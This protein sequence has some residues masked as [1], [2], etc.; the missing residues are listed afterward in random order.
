[1]VDVAAGQAA[2]PADEFDP[3]GTP[4]IRAGSVEGLMARAN[5]SELEHLSDV[6]ARKRRMKLFPAE[7]VL[8]AKSGMSAALGRVFRIDRPAYVVSHLAA[9]KPT[10]KADPSFL[11][12]WL[13]YY[14]TQRLI[15]DP[16]YPSIRLA[17][18]EEMPFPN[19]PLPEQ[20]RISAILD[21]ADALR[22]LADDAIESFDE[23][24]IA[25]YYLRFGD[26]VSNNMGWPTIELSDAL[27][28]IEG[29]WSPTCLDRPACKGEWGVLKLGAVTYGRYN[30]SAN[31]ALPPTLVARQGLEVQK[32]DIL[33]SRKNTYDLVGASVLVAEVAERLI[34]PDLI[35][36]LKL[37]SDNKFYTPEFL[38]T[39]LATKSMRTVIKSLASGAAGS[40]PNISK[41]RLNSLQIPCPPIDAQLHYAKFRQMHE[42]QRSEM[43]A[44][45][46]RVVSLFTSLQHRAF[47]GE[48]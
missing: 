10:G 43:K 20:R 3:A 17:D 41:G 34:I 15:K 29:G 22:R 31:K 16:A 18:V 47:R 28:E 36:R 11:A 13:A 9:L 2:P 21:Q 33:F 40:M 12:H 5:W 44:R 46:L 8:F 26:P 42:A 1:V 27:E 37:K 35:F 14:G 38:Q 32:G 6:S 19:V 7:T 48:L 23:I 4:F 45:S 24:L 30:P 25:D 39:T